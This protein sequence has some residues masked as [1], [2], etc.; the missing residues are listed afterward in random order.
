MTLKGKYKGFNSTKYLRA[1]QYGG[2]CR[3]PHQIILNGFWN[4]AIWNLI[5]NIQEDWIQAAS[6]IFMSLFMTS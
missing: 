2:D 3:K 1:L 5:F 4:I 6:L